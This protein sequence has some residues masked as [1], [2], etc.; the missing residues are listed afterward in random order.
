MMS[1]PHTFTG[2]PSGF[3]A[4]EPILPQLQTIGN[5][6]LTDLSLVG[7]L[8]STRLTGTA[9]LRLCDLAHALRDAAIPVIGGFHT[10]ME[11]E[12][13]RILLRGRQ[14]VVVCPARSLERM[15]IPVDWRAALAEERLLIVSPFREGNR[16]VTAELAE[17]RN[18]L[19]LALARAL[20]VGS[21]GPGSRSERLSVEAL[22]T[23]KK[24]F[25]LDLP[26]NE[27]LRTLGAPMYGVK[28]LISRLGSQ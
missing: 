17:R 22:D 27:E 18:W 6:T 5:R 10:P 20:I 19:V 9:I 3:L 8:C 25:T 13:F 21:A 14:P 11:R 2:M 15:R 24:V 12:C 4:S 1:T 26:E 23:G 7:L 16:R 28:E